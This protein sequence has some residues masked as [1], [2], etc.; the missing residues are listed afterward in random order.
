[1]GSIFSKI[2]L[3][4]D[5]L[6]KRNLKSGENYRNY[7]RKKIQKKLEENP[8]W[9]LKQEKTRQ[10]DFLLSQGLKKEHK[11]LEFGCNALNAGIP[12]LKYLNNRNYTGIDVTPELIELGKKRLSLQNLWSKKPRIICTKPYD[13]SHFDNDYFDIIWCFSVLAHLPPDETELVISNFKN[14]IKKD[15]G[16]IYAHCNLGG[17]KVSQ[18]TF[19]NFEYNIDFFKELSERLGLQ[20]K[21]IDEWNSFARNPTDPSDM[22]CFS[23]K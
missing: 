12:I 10:I 6:L 5:I 13:F 14:I 16:L 9:K 15:G 18:E 4:K 22:M 23:L 20:M 7:Y 21:I 3:R 11:L 19:I 1:M 8:D 2:K 17:T